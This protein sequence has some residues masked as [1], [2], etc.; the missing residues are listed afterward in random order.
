MYFHPFLFLLFLK[1]EAK[2]T[3]GKRVRSDLCNL[4][5][6]ERVKDRYITREVTVVINSTLD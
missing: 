4:N 1:G 2:M 6:A 3:I 5:N